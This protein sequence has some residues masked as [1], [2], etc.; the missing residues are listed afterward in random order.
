M[1][2]GF[3]MK[4]HKKARNYHNL[5]VMDI[6]FNTVLQLKMDGNSSRIYLGYFEKGKM[7][8]PPTMRLKQ[9]AAHNI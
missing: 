8:T 1:I 7:Y 5:R 4:R 9:G 2:L 6:G 3:D